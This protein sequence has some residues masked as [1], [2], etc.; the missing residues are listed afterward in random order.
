M[1]FVQ[2][3]VNSNSE[4]LKQENETYALMLYYALFSDKLDKSGFKSIYEALSL[5]QTDK[6]KYFKQ[7]IKE[8]A[9]Y[10]LAIVR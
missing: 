8:I 5:L 9:S 2:R 7:E 4:F 1:H 6:Y 10:L 3:F